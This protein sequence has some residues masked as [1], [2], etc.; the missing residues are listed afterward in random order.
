MYCWATSTAYRVWLQLNI[1]RPKYVRRVFTNEYE[2]VKMKCGQ[3]SSTFV[4]SVDN[5]STKWDV[6]RLERVVEVENVCSSA[7]LL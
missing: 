4:T 1:N 7:S 3:Y 6:C 2:V 5:T